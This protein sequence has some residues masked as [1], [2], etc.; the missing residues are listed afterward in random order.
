MEEIDL[1]NE[2]AAAG[3]NNPLPSR[4]KVR[5]KILSKMAWI[6]ERMQDEDPR[7]KAR[8]QLK[9]KLESKQI[10]EAM[11]STSSRLDQ[12][13]IG[14]FSIIVRS[15]TWNCT[16]TSTCMNKYQADIFMKK[17][18]TPR[19]L[20]GTFDEVVNGEYDIALAM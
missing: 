13:D 16:D 11:V 19:R 4:S 10:D 18:K 7:L 9:V 2:G 20:T 14:K 8:M 1:I 12:A 5:E 17:F 3:M 15:A 6:A